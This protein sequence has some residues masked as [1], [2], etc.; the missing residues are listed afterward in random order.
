MSLHIAAGAMEQ[1]DMAFP[2][3][4]AGLPACVL[5]HSGANRCFVDRAFVSQ[6]K[7]R[8][9][10]P[11]GLLHCAGQQSAPVRNLV[12]ARVKMQSLSE[13]VKFFVVDM[14]TP[15]LHAV[16]GQSWLREHKAVI[17]YVDGYVKFG[18]GVGALIDLDD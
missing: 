18:M 10:P 13:E 9:Y 1:L 15:G 16:L 6:H 8:Q 7:L 2:G 4:V 3:H 14:P 12:L 5:V 11:S 17:S